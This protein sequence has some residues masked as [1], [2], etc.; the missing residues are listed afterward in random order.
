MALPQIN[1]EP[2]YEMVVPSTKKTV[3]YRPFLVKEQRNLLIAGESK[4]T[5]QIMNSM[6]S[7]ITNCV[8]GVELKDLTIYDTDYMFTQIRSKS[9][10]ETTD[11]IHTCECGEKNKIQINLNEIVVPDVEQNMKIKIN[12]N[13]TLTMQ[14]P[15]YDDLLKN[16]ITESLDDNMTDTTMNLL[17]SCMHSVQTEDENILMRDETDEEIDRF[18]NSLTT[19]QFDMLMEFVQGM[20]IMQLTHEYDCQCGKKNELKLQGIQDFFS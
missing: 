6:L 14:Y 15:S 1:E 19:S 13:I 11:M 9:V 17:R 12:D 10:G 3:K 18:I 20:P 16:G 8:E 4:D 5:R 2:V 7:V